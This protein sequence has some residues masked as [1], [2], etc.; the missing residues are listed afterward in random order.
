MKTGARSHGRNSNV[1]S[2]ESITFSQ[3]EQKD[4]EGAQ[5]VLDYYRD[6]RQ[7]G[8]V[9]ICSHFMSS[10]CR[11]MSKS[12]HHLS[13]HMKRRH[14]KEKHRGYK[15]TQYPGFRDGKTNDFVTKS[16]S[17]LK[18]TDPQLAGEVL[19]VFKRPQNKL[20]QNVHLCGHFVRGKC[21]YLSTN[22]SHVKSHMARKHSRTLPMIKIVG[23]PGEREKTYH[24]YE[25]MTYAELKSKRSNV[26]DEILKCYYHHNFRAKVH[27]CGSC[28][29]FS[30][31]SC[32]VLN[33]VASH[34]PPM[35]RVYKI[36][37]YPR[38]E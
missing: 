22:T 32:R 4:R 12:S 38:L 34:H 29:Y 24:E 35:T 36:I 1:H 15:I 13:S 10:K 7:Q 17:Q 28:D 2:L 19:A 37:E 16:Y 27:L 20:K 6:E 23:Y 5:R 3:L 30:Y 9:H 11:Y 26:A 33:H 25:Q 14:P 8:S 31:N 21:Q 18:Q